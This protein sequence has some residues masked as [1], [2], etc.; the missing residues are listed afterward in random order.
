VV[1]YSFI[2]PVGFSLV[3]FTAWG[4]VALRQS[5]QG[6]ELELLGESYFNNSAHFLVDGS[7]VCYNVPQTDVTVG[8]EVVFTNY[9]PGVTPVCQFDPDNSNDAVMNVLYSFSYPD[10]FDGRGLG[11]LLSVLFLVCCTLY[12]VTSSDSACLIVDGLASNGRK[13][14]HWA[15]R[16]FWAATIGTLTT[17]LISA[18]G[19][20][21]LYAMQAASIVCGLPVAIAMCYLVQSITLFCRAACKNDEETDFQFAPQ[22]EFATPVYGGIFNVVEQIVIGEMLTKPELILVCTRLPT[23]TLWSLP[24]V[25]WF[26]P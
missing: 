12:F 22:P 3:W 1:L 17:V 25:C 20:E 4:G 23:F 8:D 5:R 2:L 11:T 26:Q 16:I 13:N 7:K 19:A 15:R 10:S 24:R 9:L 18:G 6:K 14:N 21:A